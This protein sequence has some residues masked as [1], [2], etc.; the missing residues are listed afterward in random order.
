MFLKELSIARVK[1]IFKSGDRKLV[2]NYHPISLLPILSM[3]I[4]G[5]V[6]LQLMPY[7]ET[8]SMPSAALYG[9]RR[10]LS[11]ELACQDAVQYFY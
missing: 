9:F 6:C 4:E 7:L 10:N 8:H 11:T 5:V 1:C 2:E 3:I